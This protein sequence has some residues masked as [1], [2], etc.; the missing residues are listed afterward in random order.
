[1]SPFRT[2]V[3][4]YGLDLE[5]H[6][7]GGKVVREQTRIRVFVSYS[8]KDTLFA[9]RLDVSLKSRGFDTWVDRRKL[10]GGQDFTDAIQGT[11]ERSQVRRCYLWRASWPACFG[12]QHICNC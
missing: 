4:L 10:E 5:I 1:M 6:A 11:I 8:R 7:I 12:F 3:S 9:D 2:A